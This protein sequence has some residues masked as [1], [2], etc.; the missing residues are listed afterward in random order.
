MG[1]WRCPIWSIGCSCQSSFRFLQKSELEGDGYRVNHVEKRSILLSLPGWV[2]ILGMKTPGTKLNFLP[3]AWVYWLCS[4]D[5]TRFSPR[6]IPM[7]DSMVGGEHSQWNSNFLCG[8][9][10]YNP[11]KNQKNKKIQNPLQKVNMKLMKN[12]INSLYFES[13]EETPI[14]KLSPFLIQKTIETHCKPINI[15]KSYEQHH[16]YTNNKSKTIRKDTKMEII[17]KTKHKTYPHPTLNFSKGVIKFPDLA[18]CSLEEIRLHLRPQGVTAV[19]RISI[20]KETRTID[21]NTYIPIFDK[22]TNLTS[23]RIGYI[24]TKIKTYI[25][26]LLRCQKCPKYGHPGDIPPVCAKCG[27]RMSKSL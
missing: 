27:I 15:K 7:W 12:S 25:P 21:T 23:I 19:R 1:G 26:N 18:S 14:T 17:W 24:N 10:K 13:I 9:W 16:Y 5:V 11:S 22:P 2:I 6:H 3:L 20:R 4:P 8:L